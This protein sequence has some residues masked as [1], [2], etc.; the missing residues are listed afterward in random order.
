MEIIETE[1]TSLTTLQQSWAMCRAL[2]KT[3]IIVGDGYGFY[4][5]RVFAS[6]ILEGAQCVAEGY[7]PALVEWAARSAGMAVAPLKV[8]DEVTLTLGMHA[9]EMRTLYNLP[10]THTEGVHLLK[11]LVKEKRVGKA[12]GAGFYQYESNPRSLWDGLL[13][14]SGHDTWVSSLDAFYHLQTRL[15]LTQALEAL[16]CLEEGVLKSPQDGDV[17][18]LLGLGFA[19]QTGG[20]FSWMDYKG[21][22]WVL[23]QSLALARNDK[24]QFTP[25]DLLVEMVNQGHSFFE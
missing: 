10:T 7:S 24:S 8:F 20:P 4:T 5:T 2:N 23:E 3:P 1:Q 22:E 19:P 6:Y 11:A 13:A 14:L 15:L 17:G 25:P 12:E 18:A 21:L 16:R 9:M